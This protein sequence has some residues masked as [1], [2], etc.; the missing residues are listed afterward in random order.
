MV[1]FLTI[2]WAILQESFTIWT[3][4]IGL[5]ISVIGVLFTHRFLP[6]PSISGIKPLRILTYPFFLLWQIYVADYSVLKMVF[7]EPHVE[8]ITIKTKLKNKTL[9]LLLVN[10]IT[11]VPGSISLDLLDDEITVLWL[12]EKS[13]IPDN[14]EEKEELIKGKLE[15]ALLKAEKGI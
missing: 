2:V 8:I 6:I 11:L 13:K 5:L 10:S 1:V 4:L 15:R 12:C 14:I 7:S 3:I 9:R